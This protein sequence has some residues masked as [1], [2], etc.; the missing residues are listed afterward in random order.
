MEMNLS[1]AQQRAWALGLLFALVFLLILL[2]FLPWYNQI[3]TSRQEIDELV[4]KIQRYARVIDSRD[5]VLE[6]VERSRVAINALGYFNTQ[7]TP[8]LA[9]AELQTL[10]K[11]IIVA[12]GGSLDSTQVISQVEEEELIHI[13]VN[14]RLTGDIPML[15]S[16]LYQIE[17]AKP[18]MM[19]EEL[20]VRPIRGVRNRTT[21]QL[22]DS[23]MVSVNMQIA[24]FMRKAQ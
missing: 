4:S 2:I 24:S 22:E 18:L 16:A 8:A 20:D 7:E 23:G 6:K 13:A 1:K 10:I 9:S 5:E 21:G 3:N 19:I 14:V 12:A 15:R 11:N 17:T